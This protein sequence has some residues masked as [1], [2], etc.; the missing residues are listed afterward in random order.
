MSDVTIAQFADVLKIPVEKLLSQLDE[1]GIAVRGAD[2]MISDDAKRELLTHLRRT[3]GHDEGAAAASPRKVT[4]SR[5]SQSEIKVA[6]AQGRAKTVT[7]EVRRK[8]TYVNR[9]VLEQENK[10]QQDELERQRQEEKA[11]LD[12][13]RADRDDIERGEREKREKEL[14]DS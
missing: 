6:S 1:A 10:V 12:K 8:R 4:L 14:A 11:K 3:H 13:E 7:V 5:R 2:D 9:D